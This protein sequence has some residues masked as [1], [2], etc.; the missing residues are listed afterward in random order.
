[1]LDT[2]CIGVCEMNA[3][4]DLCLGCGRTMGEISR[5]VSMSA[6][7]RARILAEIPARFDSL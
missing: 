5:W 6:A 4:R 7:E 3:Q 1:M 2:P